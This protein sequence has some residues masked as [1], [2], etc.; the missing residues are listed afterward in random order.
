MNNR[1]TR[2]EQLLPL[3]PF[4]IISDNNTKLHDLFDIIFDNNV[5][6]GDLFDINM[7]NGEEFVASSKD[8]FV[9]NFEGDSLKF[10][11][12]YLIRA[13]IFNECTLYGIYLIPTQNS[14]CKETL[15]DVLAWENIDKDCSVYNLFD[16][17]ISVKMAKYKRKEKQIKEDILDKIASIIPLIDK[18]KE[19]FLDYP[20]ERFD[21]DGW[22][23]LDTYIN[24]TDYVQDS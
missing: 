15:D 2:I 20:Q 19:F 24:R 12:K 7:N 18:F 22:Q 9:H 17:G 11:Y 4:D 3:I 5:K 23:L 21:L 1:M 8:T 6:V 13:L 16:Y 14:L 10:E